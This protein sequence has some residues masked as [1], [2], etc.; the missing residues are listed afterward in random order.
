VRESRL[1]DIACHHLP[2][3]KGLFYKGD[4]TY[5]AESF[6]QDVISVVARIERSEIRDCMGSHPRISFHSIRATV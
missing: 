3:L 6:L 4:D 2:P 1:P 5:P